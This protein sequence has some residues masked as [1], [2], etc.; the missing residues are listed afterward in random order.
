MN[1]LGGKMK[2]KRNFKY[3]TS[4]KGNYYN[5][6]F[7]SLFF[8]LF[9]YKLLISEVPG[10]VE[11]IIENNNAVLS[12]TESTNANFYNIY[13]SSFPDVDFVYI[14][15]VT[16]NTYTDNEASSD[17]KYFYYV[18]A[19]SDSSSNSELPSSIV[20]KNI[21]E[22]TFTMG[23]TTIQNDAPEVTVNLSAFQISEKEITNQEYIQ[24]LNA[25]YEENWIEIVQEQ[26][27]DPCGQYTEYVVKGIGNA[28]NAGQIYIQL[29]ETGGCT[30]DGFP[31]HIDNKS[32]IFFNTLNNTFELLDSTKADWPVNWVKWYGAYAFAQFYG[33]NLP[34]EAQ[35]EYAAKGGQMFDYP[36]DDGTLSLAKAN[37]NGDIPGVYN[38]DGHSVAVGSYPCN[39]FGLYDMGGECLGSGAKIIIVL[40][41]I[42]M[43]LLTLLTIIPE[44]VQKEYEEEVLG[45][46]ILQRY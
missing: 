44:L 14:A 21:P 30:S 4:N 10:D 36:T 27:A 34:S 35:W 2:Y 38:P 6:M 31:E 16:Y 7:L 40:I 37:Y 32:W 43:E 17:T 28:P 3:F 45:I 11:L 41:F 29:G 22:G 46:I 8:I 13:R 42:Q 33:V 9:F 5:K 25:A 39:P 18:T 20:L 23:G 12:W 19:E 1:V 24:F 26:L 15:S